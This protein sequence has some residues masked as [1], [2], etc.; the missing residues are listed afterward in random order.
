MATIQQT[1]PG[2]VRQSARLDRVKPERL[3]SARAADF[4]FC[5]VFIELFFYV[6]A[7]ER[8]GEGCKAAAFR[9]VPIKA[10]RNS[11]AG[12][13]MLNRCV[14]AHEAEAGRM[15]TIQQTMP[16]SVRQSAILDRNDPE[17]LS[18]TVE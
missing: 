18:L 11:F 17:R 8:R 14:V 2:S 15:A 13:V 10:R 5:C 3:G 9:I 12:L 4:L 16:G 6:G 7:L 1:M